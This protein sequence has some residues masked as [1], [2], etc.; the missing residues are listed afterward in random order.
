MSPA[1]NVITD[2]EERGAVVLVVEDEVL[3]RLSI[4]EHLRACGYT[5]V[6]AATAAEAMAVLN[7]GIE[8]DLVFSDINMPGEMDGVAL[9]QWLAGHRVEVPVVLT[10]GIAASR[11][12]AALACAQV[13]HVVPKPYDYDDVTRRISDL[14]ATRQRLS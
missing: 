5:V 1:E 14:I 6:E 3:I 4:A 9:A 12:A 11:A 10:S 2:P 7:S 13:R 8:V